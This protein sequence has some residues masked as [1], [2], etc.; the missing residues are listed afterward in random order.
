[1]KLYIDESGQTGCIKLSEKGRL[2]F[3]N[4]PVFANGAV[5]SKMKKKSK[6]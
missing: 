2:S 4:Q 3:N 5:F 1:M 6:R